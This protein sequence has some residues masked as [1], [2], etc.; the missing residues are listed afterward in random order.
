MIL[1][2][3]GEPFDIALG[4]YEER[5]IRIFEKSGYV[6]VDEETAED[7]MGGLVASVLTQNVRENERQPKSL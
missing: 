2:R 1:Y 4:E 7:A 6:N 5:D 3:K